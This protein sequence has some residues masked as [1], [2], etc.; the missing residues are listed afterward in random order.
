MNFKHNYAKLFQ[1]RKR[2]GS[3]LSLVKSV[4][5]ATLRLVSEKMA[6]D[7]LQDH[8]KSWQDPVL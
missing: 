3:D 1:V 6:R 8:V 7:P 4:S 2:N 5:L